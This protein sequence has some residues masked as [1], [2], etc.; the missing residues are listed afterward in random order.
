MVK[1]A[2]GRCGDERG[3]MMAALLVAL[4]V[5]A[6][7]MTAAL[8]AWRTAAQREK[9]AELIFRGEQYARAITLFQRKYANAS[10]P[11]IDVLLN[12]KF[13]RKKYKDPITN[14]DFQPITAGTNL[15]GPG[16]QQ[17]QAPDTRNP[18]AGR[19][20]GID[21]SPSG[22]QSGAAGGGFTTTSAGPAGGFTLSAQG[23]GRGGIVGVMSKSPLKSFRLYNGRDTYNQW[24]FMGVQQSTR[25]G[26]A[27]GAAGRAGAGGRAGVP[28]RA[29]A[30]GRGGGRDGA[31]GRQAFP[32]PPPPPPPPP[33]GPGGF[34]R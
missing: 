13:L 28:G 19:G 7:L 12:E 29:G 34:R 22:R 25:A 32:P 11:T 23:A 6:I 2:F 17:P 30:D 8:P 31:A 9:E 27:G 14:D 16:Q 18:S 5:M 1:R 3:I 10:P 33:A 20:G 4:T 26:G 24:V 15:P 21:L